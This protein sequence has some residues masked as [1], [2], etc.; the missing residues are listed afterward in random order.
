MGRKKLYDENAVLEAAMLTFW[1]HGFKG[2]STRDLSKAMGINQKSLYSTFQ[3]KENL[4]VR[5]LEYYYENITEKIFVLPLKE[6]STLEDLRRFLEQM[7]YTAESPFPKG[8]FICKSMV[9][10]VGMNAQVDAVIQ[11]YRNLIVNKFERVL[12][13]SYPEAKEDFIQNKAEFLFGAYLGLSMQKPM[14]LEGEPV[15]KYINELMKTIPLGL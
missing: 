5:S 14:G 9:E 8:C 12:Q 3:S 13:N 10:S 4:F 15:Q 2:V 6:D 7:V 11:R 1:E